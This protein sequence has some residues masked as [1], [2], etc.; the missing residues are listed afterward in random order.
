M[1]ISIF[2]LFLSWFF[3]LCGITM[4]YAN[5]RRDM[6][7]FLN[8]WTV[9]GTHNWGFIHKVI[10]KF[11]RVMKHYIWSLCCHVLGT[12]LILV[13]WLWRQKLITIKSG[14]LGSLF[15]FNLQVQRCKS[16]RRCTAYRFHL[17]DCDFILVH[18][19]AIVYTMHM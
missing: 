19:Y 12:C 18:A 3:F 16:T 13:Q 7:C 10:R 8:Q 15:A 4:I 11:S 9:F 14:F 6:L 2:F 17:C 1:R 5:R